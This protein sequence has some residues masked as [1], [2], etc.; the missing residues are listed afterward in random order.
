MMK[1]TIIYLSLSL[2]SISTFA[3]QEK[4][5]L[6]KRLIDLDLVLNQVLHDQK[7]AG[8]AVAITEGIKSFIVRD[9]VIG[10]LK[11]RSP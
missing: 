10:T 1:R 5:K 2:I 4:V 3:Q 8:F 11:N 7:V 6:D 9:L